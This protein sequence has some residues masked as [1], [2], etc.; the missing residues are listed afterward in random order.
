MLDPDP[1]YGDV[2][3]DSLTPSWRIFQLKK[4]HRFSTDDKLCA[5][6]AAE[7]MPRA[8]RLLDLG[9]GIGSVGL[10]TLWR[11][12]DPGATLVMVEAQAVSVRLARRSLALNGLESRVTVVEADLRD[13]ESE[14]GGCGDFELVT[15]SPPYFPAAHAVASE[16]DQKA[17]CRLELRGGLED[18]CRVAAR[19]LTDEGVF[20][21]VMAA[22][23]ER[24]WRAP[25]R[26]GLMVLERLDCRFKADRRPHICV[27][28]CGK[29]Q[30]TACIRLDLVLRD[31][32]GERTLDYR[33]WQ[34]YMQLRN[35][36]GT[37]MADVKVVLAD[38]RAARTP[39][40][41][42]RAIE[43]ARALGI[44]QAK[45]SPELLAA[46]RRL[47]EASCCKAC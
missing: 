7:W 26:H 31:D 4:G 18:Y 28:V 38:L 33:A 42:G 23:D 34:E 19:R 9:S 47:E 6:R 16:H 21:F 14:W 17:H 13:D 8:K 12:E 24:S 44:R 29:R 37:S 46:E 20:V 25:E 36:K 1:K 39:H 27:V 10:S 30:A 32:H 41:L 35:R 40:D 45:G 11:M 3:L 15:G 43:A 2:S 5:W 22:D